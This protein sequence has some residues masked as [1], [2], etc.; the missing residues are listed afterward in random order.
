[1]E[2]FYADQ[3]GVR[4]GCFRGAGVGDKIAAEARTTVND[5][6]NMAKR[7]DIKTGITRTFTEPRPGAVSKRLDCRG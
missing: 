5:N 6:G 7:M 2:R 4:N 1:M 3:A